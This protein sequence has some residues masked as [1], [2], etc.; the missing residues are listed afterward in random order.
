MNQSLKQKIVPKELSFNN[1]NY[2]VISIDWSKVDY[3][4]K[5]KDRH[6]FDV[7]FESLF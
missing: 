6:P 1:E 7:F 4:R 3:N 2:E 5:E